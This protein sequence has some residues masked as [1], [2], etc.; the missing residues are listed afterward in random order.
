MKAI[1]QTRPELVPSEGS[2]KSKICFVGEAPG[3][4][5]VKEGRPF[6]GNAGIQL[7]RLMTAAGI[8]RSDCYFTNVV[9]EQPIRNNIG[10]FINLKGK[11]V[12]ATKAYENYEQ[13]LYEE[14]EKV[15]SNVIVAVGGVAL[16]ALSRQL[17]I[18]KWRGSILPATRLG[19]RKLIPIIHPSAAL[20][21]YIYNHFILFDLKRVREESGFPEINLPARDLKLRPTMAET[22]DYIERCHDCKM[23]GFDIEVS[24]KSRQMTCFSLA[25]TPWDAISVPLVASGQSACDPRQEALIIK[26]LV[27]LLEDTSVVKVG[28]NIIFDASFMFKRYGAVTRPVNDTMVGQAI[29][30]PDFPKGLDFITSIHTR[31]PYYKDD[32]KQWM[33]YGM[34]EEE[35]WRYNALD[36]AVCIEAY[37]SIMEDIAEMEN[38]ASY[39]RAIRLIEPLMYMQARGIKVDKEALKHESKEAE[40]RLEELNLKVQELVGREINTA[41]PKQLMDYFYGELGIKPY[42]NRKS[43]K[44][45]LDAMALKRLARRGF[46]VAKILLEIRKISKLKGT[47]FDMPLDE[48][49]RIRCSFNPVGTVSG[50]L[51]SSKTIFGTGGNMQNIPP[52]MKEHML[53]DEGMLMFNIDLSQ[54]ENR[55]VA[56]I[57]PEPKMMHAFETGL[58]IHT[59]TAALIFGKQPEDVS[60]EPGSSTIGDGSYSERFWGKKANH[61]LNYG[62]GYRSFALHLEIEEK[63]AKYIWERYHYAYPGVGKY[64]RWVKEALRRNRSL[65]TPYGRTR[66]FRDRWGDPLFKEAYSFI[67]QSTIADKINEDGVIYLYEEVPEADLLNQVHDSIVFQLPRSLGPKRIAQ[68]LRKIVHKLSTPITWRSRRFFI[69]A[70]IEVGLTYKNMVETAPTERSVAA[71]IQELDNA[72][73]TAGIEKETS[74]AETEEDEAKEK[75]ED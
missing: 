35:F 71:A 3:S 62:L 7:D 2:H 61:S 9:K 11:T 38:Q 8:L 52:K 24:L 66:I 1:V 36:S 4:N 29:A 50:R 46:K 72:K 73:K 6:V 59:Q 16:Y 31:E 39:R 68:I 32:G 40:K 30:Y 20:R 21:N 74:E 44:R 63:E 54:A 22:I 5:E 49:N 75:A 41:S 64:H 19:G 56:Y 14:L 18:T 43:G 33:K 13:Q 26:S 70:E 55:M 57:A 65:T 25:L 45:T 51:S 27:A 37:P 15:E 17:G 34:G 47:Y 58:D 53:A 60:D 42:K 12:K 48:D 67:P 69:P 28:Q 10:Q 23:V